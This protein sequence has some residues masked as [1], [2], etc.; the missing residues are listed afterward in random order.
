MNTKGYRL[1]LILVTAS[2]IAW[3]TAGLF[4]RLIQL[5]SGMMLA[6]RCREE[7]GP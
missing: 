3:S 6:W 5:D 7:S 1:G 2:A 4:T